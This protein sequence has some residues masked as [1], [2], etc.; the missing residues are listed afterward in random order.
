M[1]TL[2]Q[3]EA[4]GQEGSGEL[5]PML[6]VYDIARLM[7]CHATKA[8]PL[9][10]QMGFVRRGNRMLVRPDAFE[11]WLKDQEIRPAESEL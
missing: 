9:M 4:E 1:S 2:P 11:Q 7:R 10:R 3:S 6:D 5:R 8:Y